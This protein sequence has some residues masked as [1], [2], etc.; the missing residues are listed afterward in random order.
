[1]CGNWN[2]C[3]KKRTPKRAELSEWECERQSEFGWTWGGL[4][5]PSL[6]M[7]NGHLWGEVMGHTELTMPVWHGAY[8]VNQK[9][10]P[11]R[12]PM[13]WTYIQWS[14]S[15]V[16]ICDS[17]NLRWTFGVIQSSGHMDY[18]VDSSGEWA[19]IYIYEVDYYEVDLS[20][21]IYIWGGQYEVDT[22][23]QWAS[24]YIYEVDSWG[25]G[26]YLRCAN[27]FDHVRMR[28]TYAVLR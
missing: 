22:I 18:E 12:A 2:G 10:W 16:H 7:R 17:H 28:W 11:Q 1:M 26:R 13:S 8:D 9:F 5:K 27:W 20:V 23:G 25:L 6:V 15:N 3:K 4:V 14:V 24:I 21:S 19:S